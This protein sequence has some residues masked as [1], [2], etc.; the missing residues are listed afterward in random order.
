MG[1]APTGKG[2]LLAWSD[3]HVG[4]PAARDVVAAAAPTSPHDW[5]LLAGDVA[6]SLESLEWA[7]RLLTHRFEKVVWAPGNHELWS[8]SREPG[9][10]RGVAH[11]ERIVEFMRELGVSTPEDPYPVWQGEGGPVTIAP[12][13]ILY[14]YSFG[15]PGCVTVQE[16]LDLAYA[17]GIVC[18]DEFFLDPAPYPSRQAWCAARVEATTARLDALAPG[19]RTVLVNHF[20]L[21]REP[22]RILR[23]TDMFS[24]WCGTTAT[25]DWHTRYHAAAV[26]YGHL[27]IPRTMVIDGVPFIEASLGYPR[28]W[29]HFGGPFGPRV[30]LDRATHDDG[31]GAS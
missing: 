22:T 11:Y 8:L 31:V 29:P 21:R 15:V 3:L 7:M 5:L 14:D 28:E 16:G 13:F 10:P 12:L 2:R 20:P 25:H 26:V 1:A 23:H 6:E 30:V 18:S 4:H 9:A 24:Q 17:A 27:H 19:I